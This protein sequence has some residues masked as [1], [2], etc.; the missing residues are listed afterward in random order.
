MLQQKTT[1]GTIETLQSIINNAGEIINI[2]GKLFNQ[3][4]S[5]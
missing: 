3:L 5:S 1:S 4:V 2:R